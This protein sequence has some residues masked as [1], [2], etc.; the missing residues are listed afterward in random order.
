MKTIFILIFSIV[1]GMTLNAQEKV[2]S[3]SSKIPTAEESHSYTGA[4]FGYYYLPFA[5]L[6]AH[7]SGLGVN[8]DAA[9]M[10]M[11]FGIDRGHN[12]LTSKLT[13][14]VTSLMSFHYL[15]PLEFNS[16]NDSL[17]VRFNGYNAQFDLFGINFVKSQMVT[18][19]GGL[20]W[21]FGRIKV[22]EEAATGK[23]V[24]L[25]KYFATEGRIELNVRLIEHFYI[26]ARYAYR[27]DLTKTRWTRTGANA[28]DLPGVNM[29][30]T[31][32]GAFIGYG[33]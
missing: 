7:F 21:A 24:F 26:G 30:G 5:S 4:G 13:H 20:G 27:A 25:N 29:S 6:D 3:K 33:N 2:D 31:M 12:T 1:V 19:T 11:G 16:L 22:T 18:F 28:K 14:S 9:S 17:K 23:S 8:T 15:L 32:I 10:M